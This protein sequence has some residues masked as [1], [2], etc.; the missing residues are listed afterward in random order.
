[1]L[2]HPNVALKAYYRQIFDLYEEQ[3]TP[4]PSSPRAPSITLHITPYPPH[5]PSTT[6][7]TPPQAISLLEDKESELATLDVHASKLRQDNTTMRGRLARLAAGA[8]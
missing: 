5:H 4:F 7:R 3:H 8:G 2:V 6:P 1:M